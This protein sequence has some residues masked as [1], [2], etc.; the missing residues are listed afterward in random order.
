MRINDHRAAKEQPKPYLPA[1]LGVVI[2]L[3][4]SA[5]ASPAQGP[6]GK[7]QLVAASQSS[8]NDLPVRLQGVPGGDFAHLPALGSPMTVGKAVVAARKGGLGMQ[9]S[10][11]VGPTAATAPVSTLVT[12]YANFLSRAGESFG[13][14]L[15]PTNTVVVVTVH[16]RFSAAGTPHPPGAKPSKPWHQYT[17]A[18]DARSGYT[19]YQGP[20]DIAG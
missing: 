10:P 9:G 13:R 3:G 8:T 18:F 15:G 4:V 14:Q 6:A 7:A 17:V 11:P 12:T 1:A 2:V 19:L 16:A 5:C 20:L